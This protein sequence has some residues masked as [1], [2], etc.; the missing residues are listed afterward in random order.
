[1]RLAEH[2]E[3]TLRFR[4]TLFAKEANKLLPSYQG[5]RRAAE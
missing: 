2:L 1:V 5:N 4:A 3:T